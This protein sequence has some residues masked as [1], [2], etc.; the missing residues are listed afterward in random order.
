MKLAYLIVFLVIN[1]LCC[2]SKVY[3][4]RAKVIQDRINAF[5]VEFSIYDQMIEE[6]YSCGDYP[7]AAFWNGCRTR[8]AE[9]IA[10]VHREREELVQARSK[11]LML[12]ADR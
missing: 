1:P 10:G 6:A 5:S 2:A 12:Q 9:E 8:L 3:Q 11:A 7:A 4:E